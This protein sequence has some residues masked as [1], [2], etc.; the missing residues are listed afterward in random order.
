MELM[1]DH[2]N[3]SI[4]GLS[5]YFKNQTG[6]NISDY[7]NRIRIEKAKQLL[8]DT[9][10]SLQSIVSQLGYINVSSFIRKF[11]ETTGTTPGNFRQMHQ[12]SK[13]KALRVNWKK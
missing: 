9:E 1:A 5:N 11:K 12:K 6:E 13:S 2:F 3:M 7:T 10:D 4:S 8:I